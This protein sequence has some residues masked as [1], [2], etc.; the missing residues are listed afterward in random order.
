MDTNQKQR[1]LHFLKKAGAVL[2]LG[3]G[4]LLW[5]RLT[6]LGIPCLIYQLTGK[7][8]PGCGISRMCMALAALDF[9]RAFR[10]NALV[11]GLLPFALI[12]GIRH[13]A[14]YVRSGSTEIDRLE[15]ILLLIALVLTI[16]FG[17]L[18]N[19]PDFTFLVPG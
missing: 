10:C 5:V 16:A 13:L 4:Y 12:F 2:A 15:F 11:M 9:R 7:L 19:L 6:G 8:C 1:L 18:R 17:L 3:L 14:R